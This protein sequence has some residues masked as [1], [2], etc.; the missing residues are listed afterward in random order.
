MSNFWN[1]ALSLVV[2]AAMVMTL[3]VGITA[4]AQLPEITVYLDGERLTFDVPPQIIN[5]RTM[6][7]MRTIFEALGAFVEWFEMDREIVAMT[8]DV[9]ISL[10]VDD[11]VGVIWHRNSRTTEMVNLDVPPIIIDNR[12]LVPIRLV[13]EMMG[14]SV[15]WDSETRTITIESSTS[16]RPQ[17]HGFLNRI[18]YGGNVAYIFGTMHA[19]RPEWFPLH[20]IAEEAMARSDVFA[21]EID[22][23]EEFD[24][25][26]WAELASFYF[27][28]NG[29]QLSDVLP[30]EIWAGF[31]ENF[32]SFTRIGWYY[33]DIAHFTP[34]AVESLI[35]Y[36]VFEYMG[37]ER[38]LAVDDYINEFAL[39][40]NR[41]VIGL[42]S[43]IE[44]TRLAMDIPLELQA[45]ALAGFPD[46][47]HMLLWFMQDDFAGIYASQDRDEILRALGDDLPEPTCC[48]AEYLN[49]IHLYVR[50]HIFA[51]EI[52]RLLRETIEPTTF[53]VAIGLA[54]II[55]SN[56]G[57]VLY[58]LADKGFDVVPLWE[59]EVE[60]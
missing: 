58:L 37:V 53:F 9:E 3:G 15:E 18:E 13:S 41:P 26:S 29:M 55:G 44:Q 1:K 20:P 49:H 47:D 16:E 50:C 52:E 12:T 27:L 33:E 28:P 30:P 45:Y 56:Q 48:L 21:F 34:L 31:R 43:S 38:A 25:N 39:A 32:Y 8:A 5:D 35:M 14:A 46:F 24:D 6:V 36:E 59:L 40:N 51:D 7:P 22:L 11:P 10:I 42:T 2:V 19:G 4:F 23:N 57:Q 17:I 60:D 54:H